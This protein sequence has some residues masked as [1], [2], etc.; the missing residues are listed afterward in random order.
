VE[1]IG[2]DEEEAAEVVGLLLLA[3]VVCGALVEAGNEVGTEVDVGGVEAIE[4]FPSPCL[5]ASFNTL[6]ARGASSL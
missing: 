6:V 5:R 4:L 3:V 1:G 2:S